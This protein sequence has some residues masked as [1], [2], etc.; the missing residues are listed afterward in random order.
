M[1]STRRVTMSLAALGALVAA[2]V[3]V[4]AA[5]AQ[6]DD[7]GLVDSD[8]ASL[9][10]RL[11]QLESDLPDDDAVIGADVVDD[12]TW[13]V[14]HGDA[15]SVRSALDTVEP[16]LRRLFVDADDAEGEV[17]DA[18][19]LVARGWLDVWTGTTSIAAAESHDLAFP[20]EATDELGVATGADELRGSAE[21]GIRLVLQ[22]RDLHHD[23]YVAL[24]ELGQAEPA[25]QARFDD[26]A[27]GAEH[28][29]REVRPVLVAMVSDP[30]TTLAVPTDRFETD[31]PGVRSR[32]TSMRVV[33][34]DREAYEAT[35]PLDGDEAAD[36]LADAEVDRADCVDGVGDEPPLD[37]DPGG[38]DAPTDL[39]E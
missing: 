9:L 8:P 22:G 6:S 14:L 2:T 26:R 34:V 35:I 16:D 4:G 7:G 31:A 19:A 15:T 36:P 11:D 33:C 17:A 5:I 10:Q 24:R 38:V 23:G 29:D 3:G 20:L 39:D 27:E 37:D 13:G 25:A 12:V 32:A 30:S 21:T 28:F 18:V 1:G